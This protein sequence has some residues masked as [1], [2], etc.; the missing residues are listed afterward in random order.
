MST[1]NLS[2]WAIRN[3]SLVLFLMIGVV[4][5]GTVAFLKLGRAEDPVFTIRTM[6]VQAHWPGATLDETLQQVTERIERTLQEVPNLDTLRSYTVPG[7]TVIF[8]DLV[9]SAHGR[10]VSDTWYEVRKRVGD[11]RHTLPQGVLGP[12]FNDDFGDTFGIIYGFTADGFTHREL[13][14]AVEDVR[15]RLLLV[16]DVAKIELLGEQDERIHVD[17]SLETLAGLG[18]EP[19]AL[20]AALQAQNAV[21]PAGVLRTGKEALSLQVSGA[22]A[23]EQ[24]ILD[25]NFVAGGRMLRLRDVAEVRRD[26]ADPPQPLF[27]VDGKPAIGLAIAMRPG[28]DILALGRNITAEM[29]RVNADL[30]VGIE[31]HPVADQARTVDE[32]ISDFITSLWQAIVIVLVVSFIALGLRAGTVV[33]ITIP[34]TLA[35]VFSVMDLAGIDLQRVS[36]GALIIALAL[37]VDDALTTVDAM[38]R[39]LAAGDRMEVAAVYAYK[40]LAFAMLSGTLVT[41]A[42]FVPIGFAQSSAGEYTFSIFAVVGIA[43]IASWLVA[44]VFAPV[45]GTMLLKPPKPGKAEEPGAVMRLYRRA[46]EAAIRARWLTIA[47]TLGLFVLAISALG[48]VPRQFFPPSDRVELMVDLRLPQNASIHATR[49]A[50]ERFDALLAK[51]PG[52]ERWSSYVGR[53]AIR[54]YLPLNVQLANPFMGQSVVVTTDVAARERLQARLETLLADEFPNAV[55]RV[56][57]LELGP[58][59]GWPLQYRVLGPDPNQVREIALRLAQVV[60]TSPEARRIN[61][62]W[63]ETARTLRVRIDQDEAR[64]LGLSSAAVAAMLDATVSGTAVTPIRDGI[65]LIDV[66]ARDARGQTLSIETL[67][68]LPVPLPNGRSVPLSQLASFDYGQDLPLVWRRGRVPTLTLQADVAPG[69]LPETAIDAL[70][71]QIADLSASLPRGYRIEVGGIAEESAKS[72]E[73]VFAVVPLMLLLVLTVLMI[74]LRSFQ[75]LFL[76]LSVVPLGLIGVVLAL[77]ASGQPLGFVAILGVLALVGMIAKNAVI[78]IEQIEAERSAGRGINDAVIAASGSRF[79]P[80]MLTAASTVLGLIPI[81]FTVFWGAMAFAIMGGLLVASLLTLIFLPTLYVAWFGRREMAPERSPIPPPF[82]PST[83]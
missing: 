74:Q 31:A 41:I 35:M 38:T 40:T 36:L 4:V 54:F 7:T 24:D 52:V 68:S 80:I 30:P 66:L 61:F 73:S 59:V 39:R 75:R 83:A 34:L 44:T 11:M 26:F 69:V 25:V 81:A 50:V 63:M 15:S 45:L 37:L 3:R 33:A 62:D 29:A 71:P 56:Y 22:F 18:V 8:V 79:R 19:G 23:S 70:A 76:V 21:R 82:P 58:P 72:R 27:R 9:G 14:D 57:P 16:P 55:A 60:G 1:F 42:G 43:L 13:R 67:R 17:F 28:G 64:R 49:E 12:G 6:V 48:L 2:A 77:L 65:Y 78:L 20:I 47:T 5:A 53:G 32:A 51:E 46:L 10:T